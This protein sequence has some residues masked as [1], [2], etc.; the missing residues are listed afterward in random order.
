MP[1]KNSPIWLV[2]SFPTIPV[3]HF[4]NTYA[5]GTPGRR[6]MPR[7]PGIVMDALDLEIPTR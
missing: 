1:K 6:P 5:L 3:L 7:M 4:I 2:G